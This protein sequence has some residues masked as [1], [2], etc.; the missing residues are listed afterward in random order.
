MA[1]YRMKPALGTIKQA[2]YLEDENGN[3]VYEGKMTKF[4]LF[5][6][7]P[8]DFV[9]HRTGTTVQHQVGKTLTYEE[10]GNGW[11]SALATKSTFKLD[12]K[13]VWDFLHDEGV[14]IN[15]G[16]SGSRIGMNYDVTLKGQPLAAVANSS[17][18]GKSLLTT[19]LFYDVTCEE[20]DLD[21]AFLVAF[22]IGMTHQTFYN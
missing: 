22:A 14:R 5:G 8:F 18:S 2:F 1:K 9:N 17:P 20:K 7:A 16:I 6:A 12:G 4:K 19:D 3:L 21:M 10:H 11:I 13:D 15:S